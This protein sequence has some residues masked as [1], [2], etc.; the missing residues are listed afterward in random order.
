MF[1]GGLKYAILANEID[2]LVG[3]RATVPLVI[4]LFSKSCGLQE[5]KA[6]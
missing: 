1:A 3:V 4:E 5:S 2:K 6:P